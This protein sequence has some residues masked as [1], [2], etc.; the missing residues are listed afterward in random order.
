M[1]VD[2]ALNKPRKSHSNLMA[3]NRTGSPLTSVNSPSSQ[4]S[5]QSRSQ[6]SPPVRSPLAQG[7]SPVQ[8][9]D[10]AASV[11]IAASNPPLN[12]SSL[13]STAKLFQPTVVS[14][15][16]IG[17]QAN[18]RIKENNTSV[19]SAHSPSSS[20]HNG[21]LTGGGSL[22]SD[23]DE[24]GE[25]L[26]QENK[27]KFRRLVKQS[28]PQ[29][30]SQFSPNSEDS[31]SSHSSRKMPP[32]IHSQ[33]ATQSTANLLDLPFQSSFF[34]KDILM[35][36]HSN[37]LHQP[38][39]AAQPF[40]QQLAQ[41]QQQHPSLM[42]GAGQPNLPM[43]SHLSSLFQFP[44]GVS[45]SPNTNGSN[46]NSTISSMNTTIPSGT[47]TFATVAHAGTVSS[48]STNGSLTTTSS[49][50]TSGSLQDSHLI[51]TKH[52]RPTSVDSSRS[53]DNT[54]AAMT[55]NAAAAAAMLNPN[56]F[57]AMYNDRFANFLSSS[58][59]VV[60]GTLPTASPFAALS[61]LGA[62][63]NFSGAPGSNHLTHPALASQF[64]PLNHHLTGLLGGPTNGSSLLP[65]QLS[66]APAIL[67]PG[68]TP[69]MSNGSAN[70]SAPCFRPAQLSPKNGGDRSPLGSTSQ[71]NLGVGSI[72]SPV[73]TQRPSSQS[74]QNSDHQFYSD[75]DDD[76]DDDFMSFGDD[77]REMSGRRAA[78]IRKAKFEAKKQ[79]KART[80]F[81]DHQLQVILLANMLGTAVSFS[82][83]RQ[84]FRRFIKSVNR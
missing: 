81:T 27:S 54:H 49:S 74:Q 46:P 13:L 83:L 29:P 53:T 76:G 44:N 23:E 71:S 55:H 22:V 34:I 5:I 6:P 20:K 63:I 61:A 11:Q 58:P 78:E 52:A 19:T 36:Q 79:R 38:Q 28:L 30:F 48:V 12:N 70:S 45:A 51:D 32:L 18:S 82:P 72:G 40:A 68:L 1:T 8:T 67:S 10:S 75:D 43:N 3:Q 73:A 84:R 14:S 33:T 17:Q 47:T 39:L 59:N 9:I 77:R 41:L 4:Q 62:P 50:A 37:F 7:S 25:A 60:A 26:D 35:K 21:S 57:A 64:A 16:H 69:G 24:E 31:S 42:F 65:S 15:D 80:A 56:L 2:V 66:T